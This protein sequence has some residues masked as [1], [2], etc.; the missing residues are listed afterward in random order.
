MFPTLNEYQIENSGSVSAGEFTHFDGN[1]FECRAV[2]C[3]EAE[4]GF[5]AFALRLPGVVSQGE[6]ISEAL[7][8]I[9]EAFRGAIV[10]YREQKME[11]PWE[12]VEVDAPKDS[13]TKWILVNV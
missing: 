9:R 7:E 2:I 3:P 5:S 4:G 12:D 13:V 8:N 1:T 10:A 11:I 6:T